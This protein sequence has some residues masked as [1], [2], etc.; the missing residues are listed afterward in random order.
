MLIFFRSIKFGWENF[1][2]N[3]S[4]SSA[5]VLTLS[6]TLFCLSLLF[7]LNILVN[8]NIKTIQ[9][10]TD[11]SLHFYPE[12]PEEK[13]LNLKKKISSFPQT[14]GVYYL[15]T[16]EALEEFKKKHQDEPLILEAL[17]ELEKNPLEP[18]LIIKAESSEDYQIIL[19]QLDKQEY[20]K[21]IKKRNFE[22][23]KELIEKISQIGQGIK[24][25]GI[26]LSS[27]F[28]IIS[29]LIIFNTIRTNIF[30]RKEEIF[31]MRLVGTSNF[32]I[33]MP[34]IIEGILCGFFACLISLFFL[35]LSLKF[36]SP[37][38][39]NFLKGYEGNIFSLFKENLFWVI[40][41]E[42]LVGL[43]VGGISS[44]LGTRKYLKY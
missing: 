30:A 36:S 19:K 17:V 41:L 2:R 22:D 24:K 18:S 8:L 34:Y 3:F 4:L 21:I 35:F 9:K 5:T 25:G 44:F 12:T 1:Y 42:I 27:L 7:L 11:I 38:F 32:Y 15:S 16:E 39:Q 23:K 33:R 43:G 10:K 40:S 29:F 26:G 37:Y 6:L 14:K 13:I 28:G 20:E 31:L